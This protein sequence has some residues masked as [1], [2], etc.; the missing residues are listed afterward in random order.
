L[1]VI[2][3]IG[4]LISLLLPAVQMAREAARRSKCLNNLKQLGL[5]FQNY[6]GVYNTFPPGALSTSAG[7]FGHS[8]LVR[9]LPYLEEEN[10]YNEFDQLGSV[11]GRLLPDS[12]PWNRRNRDLLQS[13]QFSWMFCP[14]SALDRLVLTNYGI[15]SPNVMSSTYTGISG[16][17]DH[18]SMREKNPTGAPGYLSWGGV[19]LCE[20]ASSS[21]TPAST[22][23]SGMSVSIAMIK[24]GTSH[25]M[26]V[27]EQ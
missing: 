25:T 2:A 11:T 6:H 23:V 7:E 9:I 20:P 22:V 12:Q 15:E 19:L 16:A 24:D 3:I 26:M 4:I 27:G 21:T 1:V 8:W 18:S 17:R 10:V 5:A 13:V 14:S